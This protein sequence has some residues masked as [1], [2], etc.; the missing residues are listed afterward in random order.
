MAKSATPQ[1]AFQ[2]TV[3]NTCKSYSKGLK[4]AAD[5]NYVVNIAK[6]LAC[7]LKISTRGATDLVSDVVWY[8]SKWTG[9]V[10]GNTQASKSGQWSTFLTT[11]Q[12]RPCMGQ[13]KL[14]VAAKV[15]QNAKLS[16]IKVVII[17]NMND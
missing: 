6:T 2:Y 11:M 17:I 14:E 1:I 3:S 15:T 13:Q 8:Q 7:E 10:D 16:N 12:T 9:M 5:A 4:A